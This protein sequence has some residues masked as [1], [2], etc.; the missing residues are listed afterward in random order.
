MIGDLLVLGWRALV[1]RKAFERTRRTLPAL[2]VRS[3]K[4]RQGGLP[5]TALLNSE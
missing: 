1:V 5:K 4:G 3:H 2:A